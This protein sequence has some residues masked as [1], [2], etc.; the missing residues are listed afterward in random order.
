M[1]PCKTS[2]HINLRQS[3][4][5]CGLRFRGGCTCRITSFCPLQMESWR[6]SAAISCDVTDASDAENFDPLRTH[7][8]SG[9]TASDLCVQLFFTSLYIFCVNEC[10]ACSTHERLASPGLASG[11]SSCSEPDFST[12][13]KLRSLHYHFPL[14]N[15]MCPFTVPIYS[16]A[17]RTRDGEGRG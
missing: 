8:A 6:F 16:A 15:N 11:F 1:S 7:R 9:Y 12:D 14:Y 2:E 3:L 5:N 4:H 13:V 10:E 17:R